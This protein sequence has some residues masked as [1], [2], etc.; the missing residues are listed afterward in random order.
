MARVWA[1]QQHGKRG[2]TKVVA[3]KTIIPSLAADQQFE[4]MFLDEAR[5]ASGVHHPN[6]CEIFDLG[7]EAGVLYLA[8]EW[9]SGE[10]LARLV[11]IRREGN[12]PVRKRLNARAAA[13]IIADSAAGLHSAH[14]LCDDA[15]TRLD[16]VHRDVSPQNIL[17]GADG[18]VKVTDFGVAKA[19]GS[20]EV[21]TAGQIKGKAAYM[22]P[23]QAA[24]ARIDRRSDVYALGIC[25][26]EAT[27]GKRPF[28]GGSQLGTLKQVISGEFVPPSQVI[29]SYPPELEA[30][31]LRAMERDP[32]RRYPTAERM[33]HALEE[34]I[35]KSGSLVT[36]NQIGTVVKERAGQAIGDR[37]RRI[38][39]AQQDAAA[40]AAMSPE[41]RPTTE[42]TPSAPMSQRTPSAAPSFSSLSGSAPVSSV[43]SN[44]SGPHSRTPLSQTPPPHTTAQPQTRTASTVLVGVGIGAGAFI[45][46]AGAILFTGGYFD[47]SE[48]GETA[49]ATPA[50]TP[51]PIRV[52]TLPS[53]GVTLKVDG[54]ELAP[55]VKEIERPEAG[56]PVVLVVEAPSYDPRTIRIDA[57]TPDVV[58]VKL[59][60]TPVAAPPPTPPPDQPRAPARPQPIRKPAPNKPPAKPAGP[61]IPDNPFE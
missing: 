10:S 50:E 58:E 47:P 59:R 29:T 52:D 46:V 25:L 31:V 20:S 28:D 16:V 12:Q 33:Q 49:A 45:L 34:W 15:G 26:Y 51:D 17:V 13:R 53:K 48:P 55:G 57:R 11:K 7:E 5:V 22:A 9:V 44:L 36:R 40:I 2:F 39:A 23:E 8:M 4:A 1:A 18:I 54:V 14:E 35:A 21:T 19:L 42:G 37:Q 3:I 24:G 43:S 6:V 32:M 41:L 27:T 30:I 38:R 61:D 60:K 56:K